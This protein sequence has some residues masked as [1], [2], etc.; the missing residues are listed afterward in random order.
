[1]PVLRRGAFAGVQAPCETVGKGRFA[2]FETTSGVVLG[3]AR[4]LIRAAHRH[5]ATLRFAPSLRPSQPP[6]FAPSRESLVGWRGPGRAAGE[7]RAACS[8]RFGGPWPQTGAALRRGPRFR[9]TTTPADRSAGGPGSRAW[10]CDLP[11]QLWQRRA[12]LPRPAGQLGPCRRRILSG[13]RR[14]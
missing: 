5:P 6:R 10:P 13:A 11:A 1:T 7:A 12:G 4:I 2:I 14:P 8:R 9:I 3:R